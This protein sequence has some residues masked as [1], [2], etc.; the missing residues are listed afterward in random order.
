MGGGGGVVLTVTAT[1][2]AARSIIAVVKSG[3][4]ARASAASTIRWSTPTRSRAPHR[5]AVFRSLNPAVS[6]NPRL[7]RHA[8]QNDLIDG[9]VRSA[10]SF[11]A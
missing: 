4:S 8:D 5:G 1:T 6:G 7:L 10:K 9:R 3:A 2:E 11:T